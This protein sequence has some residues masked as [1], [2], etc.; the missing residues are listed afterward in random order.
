MGMLTRRPSYRNTHTYTHSTH[1]QYGQREI[2]SFV[3]GFICI[4]HLKRV[5]GV[6]HSIDLGGYVRR[7]ED[8]IW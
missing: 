3:D 5:V 8:F 7:R 1:M 6:L 2:S 4:L